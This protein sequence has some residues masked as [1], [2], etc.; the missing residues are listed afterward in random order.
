MRLPGSGRAMSIFGMTAAISLAVAA[1]GSADAAAP[2]KKSTPVTI[3]Y[4]GTFDM[5]NKAKPESTA[6]SYTF[7]VTWSYWWTGT[8][9]SLFRDTSVFRS[10]PVPFTKVKIAGGVDS[11]WV[12]KVGDKAVQN[13]SSPIFRD[14]TNRPTVTASYDTSAN[15]L[16]VVVEAP[17][18]RGIKYGDL[19]CADGPGTNVFG[20]GAS[21]TP[22]KSF[23]PLG[24]GGTVKLSTGGT[25]AYTKSSTWTHT[26]ASATSPP[27][28]RDVDATMRSKVTVAYTP[29]KLIPACAK[30]KP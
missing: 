29:C 15:T 3:L 2:P 23:N 5:K 20:P 27:P 19:N 13:C 22:P 9:G 10:S 1:A 25:V 24:A 6:H 14:P 18:F 26:Y 21:Q 12:N 8:W 11:T 17:T 30:A 16:Q 7:T 4:T 28:T